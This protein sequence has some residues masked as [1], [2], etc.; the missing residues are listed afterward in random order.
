VHTHL[1]DGSPC[2]K[3]ITVFN[4]ALVIFSGLL[5]QKT[6]GANASFSATLDVS[7]STLD[8]AAAALQL[9]DVGNR[10]AEKCGKY[11]EQLGRLV[12]LIG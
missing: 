5:I 7:R 9:L 1:I 12:D 8:D 2:A 10:M 6:C 4:A 11:V 3:S